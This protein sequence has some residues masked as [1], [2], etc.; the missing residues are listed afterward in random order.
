MGKAGRM[1]CVSKRTILVCV[2]TFTLRPDASNAN[3]RDAFRLLVD[4]MEISRKE[5]TIGAYVFAFFVWIFTNGT[6]PS[7]VREGKLQAPKGT[8]PWSTC[9]RAHAWP[10]Q[11]DARCVAIDRFP[12]RERRQREGTV[13]AGQ[14]GHRMRAAPGCD[15]E[16]CGHWR[17]PRKGTGVDE[18]KKKKKSRG[19][20]SG[21]AG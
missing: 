8:T 9:R 18:K 4:A 10:F 20:R 7:N 13:D 14:A 12:V 1:A 21:R 15:N 6:W 19:R 11:G 3:D 5:E 2:L 16:N 17:G